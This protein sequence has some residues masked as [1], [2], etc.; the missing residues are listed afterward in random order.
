[1]KFTRLCFEDLPFL[2]EVRNKYAEEFLHDS[3]K[4]TL[5]ETEEWF[6][7][8]KPDYRIIWKGLNRIGYF[9]LGNYSQENKNIY[10]GADI[11]K[12][13]T[14]KGLGKMSYELFLPQLF[15]EYDL[16]KI[17]LEVLSTNKRAISLYRKLGF[18]EEG[19]KRE[20]VLKSGVYVDSIIMSIL[21]KEQKIK[22]Q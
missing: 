21:R 18:I 6:L 22:K 9:R 4:F 2:N 20:D 3:R 14:G 13:Y 10:V 8:K 11:H 15:K 5:Q 12:E 17:S 7:L 1:M 19:I 16:H